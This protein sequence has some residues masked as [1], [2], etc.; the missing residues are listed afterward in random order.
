MS[1]TIL[2]WSGAEH[3]THHPR[4]CRFCRFPS[5]TLDSGGRPTHKVCLEEAIDAVRATKAMAS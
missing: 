4:P 2:D 5:H 1:K 3:W